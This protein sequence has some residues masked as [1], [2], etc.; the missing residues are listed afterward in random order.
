MNHAAGRT[1]SNTPKRLIVT[2]QNAVIFPKL[3][4]L[5]RALLKF[6]VH[7]QLQRYDV[8]AMVYTASISQPCFIA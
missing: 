4:L 3:R 2:L 7:R 6:D 8:S 5:R 1:M